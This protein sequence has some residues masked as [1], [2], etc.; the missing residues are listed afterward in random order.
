M[1]YIIA[2][3]FLFLTTHDLFAQ[4]KFQIQERTAT[5]KNNVASQISVTYQD[6]QNW[7][8]VLKW[9]DECEEFFDSKE[10]TKSGLIFW[11]LEGKKY[12]VEVECSLLLYQ[13][14]QTYF[15]YDASSIS[16]ESHPLEF[17][18]FY[19]ESNRKF[20]PQILS[21]ISGFGTFNQESKILTVWRKFRGDSDCGSLATYK[22]SPTGKANLQ[23]FRSKFECDGIETLPEDYPLIFPNQKKPSNNTQTQMR[24]PRRKKKTK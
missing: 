17:T 12:I 6:R 9:S 18:T 13:P 3:T 1:K 16:P 8:E 10:K 23:E 21:T 19:Q 7:R 14:V 11:N 2:I 24:A 4:Q 22:I 5:E 20:L 15:Y